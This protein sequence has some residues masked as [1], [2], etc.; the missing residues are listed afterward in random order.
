MQPPQIEYSTCLRCSVSL[1]RM[2]ASSAFSRSAFSRFGSA[3]VAVA[4]T[5]LTLVCFL[6]ASAVSCLWNLLL[7]LAGRRCSFLISWPWPC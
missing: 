1:S 4:F 5:L 6:A 7:R 2:R 3:T